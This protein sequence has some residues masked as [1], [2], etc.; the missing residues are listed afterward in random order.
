MANPTRVHRVEDLIQKILATSL[1][2]EVKDPRLQ[3]VT[4]LEVR[5]ARDLSFA[6]VFVSFLAPPEDLPKCLKLLKGAKGFLRHQIAKQGELRIVPELE[7]VCDTTT[8]HAMKI[9]SL[10]A[11]AKVQPQGD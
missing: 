8:Q 5:V 1:Q 4:I 2:R 10:L 3:S 7:F 6:K 11:Q 9:E